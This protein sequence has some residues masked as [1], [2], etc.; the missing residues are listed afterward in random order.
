[1]NAVEED[2]QMGF[3]F[4]DSH[5]KKAGAAC[6]GGSVTADAGALLLR[7]VDRRT[8][9]INRMAGALREWRDRRCVV[10]TAGDLVRY[11]VFQSALGYED[12]NDGDSLR[13]DPALKAACERLPIKGGPSQSAKSAPH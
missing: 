10:E 9:I 3:S 1:M 4:A 13:G 11:R 2:S 5:S 7:E 12:A 8:G 6:D